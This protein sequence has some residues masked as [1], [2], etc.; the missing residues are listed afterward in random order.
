MRLVLVRHGETIWNEEGRLQGAT[1]VPL[2]QRGRAQAA[3]LAERLAGQTFAAIYAS[4]LRRASETAAILAAS[5]DLPVRL[6]P[7]LR[8][9]S[10]GVWEGLT[11]PDIEERYPDDLAR[12]EVDRDHPPGGAESA[13]AVEARVRA[14]LAA[15]RA[16][17]PGD[18]AVLLVGHG[19]TLRTLICVALGIDS[20]VGRNLQLDN[21]SL[22]KLHIGADGAALVRLNDTCHLRNT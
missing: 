14:A 10:K 9:Q 8:E 16:A 20:F 4:D 7:R 1:D 12:W 19:M 6:D 15:I 13:S 5:H 22:S 18:E 11:W 17:H 2:S 3:R 21:T